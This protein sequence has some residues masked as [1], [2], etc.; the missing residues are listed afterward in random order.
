MRGL[1]VLIT[2]LLLF[3]TTALADAPPRVYKETIQPFWFG[4][5]GQFWYR[6]ELPGGTWEFVLV[7]GT[8]GTRE[9]AFDH[10]AV[11]AALAEAT[12][13][14]IAAATLPVDHLDFA[15]DGATVDLFGAQGAWRLDRSTGSVTAAEG[16]MAARGIPFDRTVRPSSRTGRETWI[17]F[18][19]RWTDP[20]QLWWVDGGGGRILYY[21]LAP[22]E[23]R[24]QHTFAGHV[25]LATDMG[26]TVLAVFEA[27]D[28]EGLAVVD[29]SEPTREPEPVAPLDTSVAVASPDGRR[30]VFVRDHNLWLRD[31][32][33]GGESALSADGCA[34]DSYRLDGQ[35]PRLVEMEYDFPAPPDSTPNVVWSPDSEHVVAMRTRAVTERA[36][37]MV[38]SAPDDQLQPRLR[39]YPYLKPGDDLPV[40]VPHLFDVSAGRQIPL[41][42]SLFATPWDITDIHWAPDGS[43][44]DFLYNERGHQVLRL[45]EVDAATGRART[46]VE[47][48]C[49]TF[50][51]YSNKTYLHHLDATGELVWMSERDGWNHLY[52]VDR[53]RGKVKKRITRGD[54]VVR[55]V[56]RVDE[57]V[58]QVWFWASGVV[59]GQ[60]PYYLHLCRVDLDGRNLTVLTEGDGTHGVKWSPDRGFFVDTWSRVDQPPRHVLRRASDGGLACALE[61]ADASELLAAGRRFPER[62][63]AKGRDGETDIFGIIRRPVDFDVAK[64]YPVIESIYA[65][66]HGQHVPKRFRGSYRQQ[67][68]VDRGFIVVQIDGMGTNWRSKAFHDVCWRN[69][70]DGGFP[71]R[72]VWIE[73]AAA[74]HPEMDISRMGIFGGSAGG[75]NT[76]AALLTHGDFY[77]VG[78]ADCGC[79]D[80]R[81]DKI[82]WNEQW[83]G[84]PVGSHYAEQSNV[85]LAPNLTGELLLIVGEL[86][87]N[88]DPASTMQVVDALIK[89][90]KDFDM[91]VIPG[92][93]HG[94]AGTTYGKRR[95]EEYFAL[96]LLP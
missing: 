17:V 4:E 89:A 30:A 23:R 54:W 11:A 90:D 5:D 74:A 81:M 37:Y 7:D 57:E 78:V 31:L 16:A 58:R 44:F 61:E 22:G 8:A 70:V 93:G 36:V 76:V 26:G 29:G 45:V 68:L 69:I 39:S 19:N 42:D 95:L 27:P 48:I 96:K 21:E 24:R 10:E 3:S 28:A 32:A 33:T 62:F 59:P 12:G 64:T 94:A 14:E 50:F 51:D 53:A 80:N 91:L 9:P 6:N 60:D 38:E 72:R 46:V 41:D 47:D 49:D 34:G 82:W 92:A 86:D 65:G 56:D 18:L 75:Q 79:H 35:R 52:L 2:F 83:L 55:W 66:P 87:H 71:D 77:H 25:W 85:T 84:Y 67:S 40:G 73:S 88:V 20:I 63:V 15:E 1:T 43:R 13:G